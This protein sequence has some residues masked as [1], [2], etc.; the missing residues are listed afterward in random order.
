MS[1]CMG[2][3]NEKGNETVCPYCGLD[4]EM[5]SEVATTFL[6]PGYVLK[7]RYTIGIALGQ[8]GFGITYIGYDDVLGT[9]VAI[10][11]YYP[12]DIAQRTVGDKTVMAFTRT[13]D[14]Y[15][16]GKKRFLEEAR[17]LAKFAEHPCI[18]GV[19]DCFEAN[20]TAYMV[21]QYLDGVDLKQYLEQ[22]GGRI[23]AEDSIALLTPIMDALRAVHKEGIIHRDISPDN[24]FITT[25][26]Q[27]RLIDF[28]AAR[29]S[30]NEQK[31]ISIM[32]KP[33]YAPEEQYR[34][35]GNQGP[36]TDVYALT[37]T[38]YRMI[39]G[40]P[41]SDSLE[42]VMEDDLEIPSELPENVRIALRKG[43]AV[44]AAERFA[45]IEQLQSALNGVTDNF[46]GTSDVNNSTDAGKYDGVNNSHQM[47]NESVYIQGSAKPANSSQQKTILMIVASVLG[48]LIFVG[49][50]VFIIY[51]ISGSG[52][53][54]TANVDNMQGSS[55]GKVSQEVY[56]PPNFT[57][58]SASR[59]TTATSNNRSYGHN[60][61]L[62]GNPSTA[63]NV[64][65]GVGEWIALSAQTE[66][67]IKGLRILNG[68]TKYSS[69][70]GMWLY[71]AN[72][73][74]K[75]I[76]IELSDGSKMSYTLEDVFNNDNYLYQTIDFGGIKKTA[77]VKITIN[78]IYRGSKWNDCCISEIQAY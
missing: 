18:V 13:N 8:G 4:E 3:M 66:Q 40:V 42:R 21:M 64:P 56:M 78:S 70:Y 17:M 68:Y 9:K 62:D 16:K 35:H 61:V 23:S 46:S 50:A 47:S 10:K 5:L 38:L 51:I 72:S 30:M 36:W 59:V 49:I 75:D 65:N 28:G 67:Q 27:V 55:V 71:Y 73:R 44:R 39:T 2:C 19:K 26:G 11:E 14:D 20:G 53:D 25:N 24:I 15:I 77:W 74:P 1:L 76:T 69:G 7:E 32:L 57:Q 48:S 29:Q 12:S 63:W 31:S 54:N 60:L 6:P 37:A 41:P 33:G 45:S 34:S 43:L 22:K 58:T 52:L